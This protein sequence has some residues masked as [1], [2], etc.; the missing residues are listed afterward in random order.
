MQA[1]AY[2]V[3]PIYVH[4]VSVVGCTFS[5]ICTFVLLSQQEVSGASGNVL[6][7][8]APAM[9]RGKEREEPKAKKPTPLRKVAKI[10][11]I[12]YTH[13]VGFMTHAIA[14]CW[15]VALRY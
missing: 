2:T 11:Q 4:G 3:I 12:L 1:C 14:S 15:C 9:R 13:V 5:H 6:D 7:S 10:S 8:T